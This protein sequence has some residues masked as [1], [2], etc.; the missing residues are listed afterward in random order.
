MGLDSY[1]A[2]IHANFNALLP[3][4]RPTITTTTTT[5]IRIYTLC[6]QSICVVLFRDVDDDIQN[7]MY[8][9]NIVNYNILKF[10]TTH[11]LDKPHYDSIRNERFTVTRTYGHKKKIIVIKILAE[12]SSD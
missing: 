1:T 6:T 9:N 8:D 3:R 10:K 2:D 7:N 4:D 5:S 11:C 12:L